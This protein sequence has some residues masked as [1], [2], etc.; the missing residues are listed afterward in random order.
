MGNKKKGGGSAGRGGSGSS[1][2]PA[3]NSGNHRATGGRK[4][5]RKEPDGPGAHYAK[6]T[7]QGPTKLKLKPL[8]KADAD[9]V[10]SAKSARKP[11]KAQRELQLAAAVRSTIARN[12]R[13]LGRAK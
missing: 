4:E 13:K 2:S 11:T 6:K 8:G 9:L 1:Y 12:H 7:R 10:G 5:N 3:L